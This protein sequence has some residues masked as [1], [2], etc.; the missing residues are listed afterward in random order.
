MGFAMNLVLSAWMS[1]ELIAAAGLADRR[2]G[3]PLALRF[4]LLLVLLP[5]SGGSGLVMLPPLALWLAGYVAW[6]W[7]SGRKPG[8]LTRALGLG[9]LMTL[10]PSSRST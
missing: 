7:W 9:L 4:G 5:L 1:F 6:G 8:A 3:W 2:G 10:R